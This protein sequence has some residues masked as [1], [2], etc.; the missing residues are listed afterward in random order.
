M[1]KLLIAISFI[2]VANFAV[3]QTIENYSE[4]VFLSIDRNTYIT[5][6]NILFSATVSSNQ[7]L[8][9]EI[10]Y[11]EL[12]TPKGNQ[13]KG[14]KYK[15]EQSKS[16]GKIRI[17]RDIYSGNYYIRA[18]T[19]YMRNFG[20]SSYDYQWIKIINP[21]HR[22]VLNE[23]NAEDSTKFKFTPLDSPKKVSI[24]TNKDTFNFREKVNFKLKDISP[25]TFL[26][27]T[28]SVIPLQTNFSKTIETQMNRNP[29]NAFYPET[30]GISLSGFL[31]DKSSEE[32]LIHKKI[33]LTILQDKKNFFY[34]T[35]SDNNGA[36]YF[37]LPEFADDKD[38]FIS[39]EEIP[40]AQPQL[41][42]EKD[43]CTNSINLP[44]PSFKLSEKEQ[45]TIY[46]LAMNSQVNKHFH[47]ITNKDSVSFHSALKD[48]L[49]FY[50]LPTNTLKINNY[51]EL[52]TLED[53]FKEIP[54]PVKV[55]EN[56]GKIHFKIT[57]SRPELNIYDPLVM[58]DLVPVY[59]S[60]HILEIPPSKIDRIEVI[61]SPYVKG[62]IMYGG[63]IH[64]IS[65]NNDLAGVELPESGM[66]LNY[67]FLENRKNTDTEYKAPESGIIPD[68]RNTLYWN[69]DVTLDSS[70]PT[71]LSFKTGDTDETYIIKVVGIT[72]KGEKT[73]STKCFWVK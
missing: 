58:V 2:L 50:G 60:N 10:L 57:G 62:E 61:T 39:P 21:S 37:A 19:K 45:K 35:F 52:P 28:I 3:C 67:L 53:Y 66:F 38:I 8:L 40:D 14:V 11:V 5:E 59:N 6:E 64:F 9:S 54:F 15:I 70:S 68:A 47:K 12:I 31:K 48:S 63:I 49:P 30:R 24:E 13:I 56:K 36:F 41:Y 26:H 71:N 18:Y 27:L 46:K 32:P 20:P 55:K 43:F 33:N 34:S 7:K 17:P 4:N 16:S 42:I 51:I 72:K 29:S 22:K 1:K 44:N 65:A 73:V 23:T 69:P 25:D